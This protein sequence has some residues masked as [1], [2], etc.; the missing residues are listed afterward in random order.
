MQAFLT[1]PP[2]SSPLVAAVSWVQATLL[3][4]VA[5][6]V[7]TIAVAALGFMM[8]SGRLP[9]RQG[10]TAILGCFILFGASTAAG[11]IR[12]AVARI[13]G[14]GD[15]VQWTPPPPSLPRQAVTPAPPPAPAPP[16]RNADPFAGAAVPSRQ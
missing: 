9:V 6:V 16:P 11:G 1:D 2:G 15:L 12:D 8:L 4:T 3:G 14:G 7:A 5:T 13:G 10:L